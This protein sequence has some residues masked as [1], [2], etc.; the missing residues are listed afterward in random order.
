MG[1]FVNST[2][3]LF[4]VIGLVVLCEALLYAFQ[5]WVNRQPGDPLRVRS[6]YSSILSL[7]LAW[8]IIL[9]LGGAWIHENTRM[10]E[11]QNYQHATAVQEGARLF[12]QYCVPCH[13]ALGEGVIGFPL[14]VKFLQG[15]PTTDSSIA[16]F[17]TTVISEGRPGYGSP[18]WVATPDGHW[19]SETQMPTW[20][21]DLNGP[22][23]RDE[24]N[25][26]VLLIMDGKHWG[27]VSKYIPEVAPATQPVNL[28]QATPT[29]K[30]TWPKSTLPEAQQLQAQRTIEQV[31][32]MACHTIG[33]AG[34]HVGPDI[35]DV[36]DWFK[37]VT[38]AQAEQF[39]YNWIADP[40]A[41]AKANT[42]APVYWSA[43]FAHEPKPLEYGTEGNKAYDLLGTTDMPKLPMTPE[44]RHLIV[45]YL[46]SFTK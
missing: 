41:M 29:K 44:Q 21:Q 13:G 27:D 4:L 28:D 9:M 37:G 38:P 1:I 17:L 14:N 39:V 20:S 7:V 42:R 25:D 6:D 23:T 32:C 34:A 2:V 43:D 3:E 31:G 36:K 10:S 40:E 8:V 22:L 16:D 26:L 24:I 11:T 33:S 15:D 18:T 12:A 46:F 19:R 35:T 45:D 30:T 5:V